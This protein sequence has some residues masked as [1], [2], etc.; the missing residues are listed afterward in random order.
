MRH[1]YPTEGIVLART[2]VAEES[3][4][5]TLLTKELGLVRARAQ[6]V[7]KSGAKLSSA[8]QTWA[9]SEII[10]V[11]GKEGWRISGALLK[12]N[13]FSHITPDARARASHIS[14]LL[15]RLIHGES[16]DQTIF[17]IFTGFLSALATLPEEL[18]DPLE[19]LAALRLL[20]AL[21]LDAGDLPG[22]IPALYTPESLVEV[23]G[24]R[25]DFVARVN[26]GISASGL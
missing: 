3:V 8:L 19:C 9:E 12:Q 24:N 23:A 1:K 4:L 15:L 6:G 17:A 5:V 16:P 26:R 22:T 2:L 11:H 18:H 21:G 10:L 13:W 20:A 7:R 14:S 25:A